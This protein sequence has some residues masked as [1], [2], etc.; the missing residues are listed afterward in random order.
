MQSHLTLLLA[1]ERQ[2]D[3]YAAAR[4]RVGE[5]PSRT[6]FVSIAVRLATANDREALERVA[7]LD[8]N[9]PPERVD[10]GRRAAPR[11]VA[12][13][14]LSDGRVIADPFCGDSRRRRPGA[15]E[16]AAARDQAPSTTEKDRCLWPAPP[17]QATPARHILVRAVPPQ[18][19][20]VRPTE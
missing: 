8:S 7:A 12:A 5:T 9:E 15:P 17:P 11:P 16:S 19:R 1:R 13:L 18:T 2:Q 6:L 4:G 20:S 14:W 10:A 3:L